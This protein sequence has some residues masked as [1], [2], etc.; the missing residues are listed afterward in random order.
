MTIILY[1]IYL[2]SIILTIILLSIGLIK[3]NLILV[4]LSALLF[5]THILCRYYLHKLN[6]IYKF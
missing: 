4:I 3:S 5:L 6:V 1:L 2:I